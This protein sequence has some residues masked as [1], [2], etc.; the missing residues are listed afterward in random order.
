MWTTVAQTKRRRGRKIPT[1]TSFG[2]VPPLSTSEFGAF[3]HG[4]FTVHGILQFSFLSPQELT[5][6][7][8]ATIFFVHIFWVSHYF[9]AL[10]P[11]RGQRTITLYGNRQFAVGGS[12]RFDP[13]TSA[14]QSNAPPL[15]H[16]SS[17]LQICVRFCRL[18]RWIRWFPHWAWQRQG[19]F[20]AEGSGGDWTWLYS[21]GHGINS[22]SR[23]EV[24]EPK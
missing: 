5:C 23:L 9:V 6:S 7:P 4:F 22:S 20:T 1:P 3:R 2:S 13:G 17:S 19:W 24:T 8:V 11:L 10:S 18:I 15:R 14:S 21:S 12:A 16:L